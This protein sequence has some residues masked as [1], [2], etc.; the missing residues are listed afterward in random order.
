MPTKGTNPVTGD[1]STPDRSGGRL[2]HLKEKPP[3]AEEGE[4]WVM[5]P[6]LM[7][8]EGMVPRLCPLMVLWFGGI[9]GGG[10]ACNCTTVTIHTDYTIM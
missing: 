6:G 1:V 8:G 5:A 9:G 10:G 3:L 7:R 4:R 2:D